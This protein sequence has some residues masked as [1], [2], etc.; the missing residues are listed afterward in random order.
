[1]TTRRKFIQTSVQS[2]GT[3]LFLPHFDGAWAAAPPAA[4]TVQRVIDI[5]MKDINGGTIAAGSVDTIKTGAA[6]TVVT[7]IICTMFATMDI[8]AQAKKL[9]ANFIIAHEPTF[10]N[11]TDSRDY[12]RKNQVLT[13]K[14]TVME[15]QN[16][17][18]WRFHDYC[19]QI[20]PEPMSYGIA[21]R[22]GWAS[23]YKTGERTIDIPAM[24][25][26]ALAAHL[27]KSLGIKTV[28]VIGDPAQRCSKLALLP[29]ASGGQS[30][31]NAVEEH[32]PDV[33]IV[34]E[35]HEWETAEYIRD[36]QLQGKPTS[37]II[38]GHS[39]SEEPGMEI[40]TE[41]LQPRLP[42]LKIT[43]IASGDPFTWV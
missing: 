7:G 40:V 38:L 35:V 18:V 19:H 23:N 20:K 24:R 14:L 12:V 9:G 29:G 6:D 5:V 2:A 39:V 30:H 8:I 15:R 36:S 42:G 13:D 25:L 26:D 11:H 28:R 41:W 16:V 34:G 10:Y 1:M 32:Q 21:R 31:L 4:L 3:L 27:K 17:V 37:L 22:A 43:H 33:L